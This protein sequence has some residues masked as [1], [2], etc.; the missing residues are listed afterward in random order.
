MGGKP[1]A[2]IV[3]V[4]TTEFARQIPDKTALRLR[5]EAARKAIDDAGLRVFDIDGILIAEERANPR[6]HMEFSE[7]M[8][9][10]DTPLCTSIP[11]GG[12]SPGYSVE[13]A[14]WALQEGRCKYVLII[15]GAKESE[16]APRTSRGVGMTDALA[17]SPLHYPDY[18]HPYGPLMPSFYAIVAQ[19]HI[20]EY[21]TTV[22]QLSGISVAFRYNASLNP[23]AIYRRPITIEDVMTSRIISSP[24]RLLHCCM[25]NDGAVAFVMTSLERANDLRQKP[26]YVLSSGACH[27]GYWTGFLAKGDPKGHYSL[28]RTMGERAANDAF[29]AAGVSRGDIDLVTVCDNFAITPLVLL[30]DYGFCK[31]GEGGDFVGS[32]DRLRVGGEL[33]VNPHGGLLSCNHAATNYQNYVE[34]TLQLQGRAGARQVKDAKLALATCCA[35]IISTHYVTVLAAS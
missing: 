28:T 21:R 5:V 24:L 26:V 19:R 12:A 13:L 33:P 16:R 9:L 18:E 22:E 6:Y 3:G 25:V 30:E 23:D 11:M 8:G 10:Y 17:L 27:H 34:A 20:Y 1:R 29:A 7:V 4:G 31:K 35:G 14:T 15:A 2:A 32:G